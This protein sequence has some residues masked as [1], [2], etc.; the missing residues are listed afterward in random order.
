M[1][2]TSLR[3]LSL[4]K[5]RIEYGG[6]ARFFA[7]LVS[8]ANCPHLRKVHMA[9]VRFPN[10]N[11]E[12]R[13]EADAHA[14]S[15]LWLEDISVV[16]LELR[17]PS[18]RVLLID[19]VY[20]KVLKIS[21]PGLEELTLF[22]RQGCSPRRG[23][24]I[25]GDL[26]CVRILKLYMWSYHTPAAHYGDPIGTNA[27]NM[28]ILSRCSSIT[29]LDVT[30][31]GPEKVFPE[32]VEIIKSRVPN[33]PHI[34]SLTINVSMSFEWRNFGVGVANLLTRF[35][36]LKRL[37]LHLPFPLYYCKYYGKG[38][39]HLCN[40]SD[41]WIPH[42]EISMTHL[43]ELELTGLTG[44]ECELWLTKGMV[45]SATG[46]REVSIRFNTKC[47]QHRA[48]W[49]PLSGCCLMKECGFPT[50]TNIR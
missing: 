31:D 46:L 7:H 4:K 25:D 14:L 18:L 48:R 44:T 32:D 45:T 28:L 24:E 12:M 8:S 20:H 15:E 6:G 37:S 16:S 35:T 17:T 38:S 13:L 5:I 19:K 11:A 1:E 43:H 30:L 33:L 26:P 36:N 49:M 42:H 23:I 10:F 34:T 3:D 50:A 29:C 41:H 27:V 40:H 21:A 47:W 39:G 2:F 22:F 9:T